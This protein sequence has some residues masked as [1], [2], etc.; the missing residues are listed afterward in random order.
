MVLERWKAAAPQTG[1]P[2][3]MSSETAQ[4][5]LRHKPA[6]LAYSDGPYPDIFANETLSTPAWS[7][8]TT[9]SSYVRPAKSV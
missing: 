7:A 4:R 1:Q 9:C 3:Y 5:R 6:R 2:P 8:I